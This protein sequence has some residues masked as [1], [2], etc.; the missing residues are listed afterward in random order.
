MVTAVALALAGVVGLE[1]NQEAAQA[2][3]GSKFDPGLIISDSVYY[4]FGAMTV[5]QVQS[6]LNSK[7]PKC[8]I[9]AT[10]PFTCL[11]DFHMDTPAKEAV[12]GRCNAIDAAMNQ[13]AAE[14]I[15]TVGRACSINPRVLLVTLQKSKGSS[16][17]PALVNPST[18]RP[19]ATAAQTLRCAALSIMGSSTR[20]TAQPASS[21]GMAT[22][23]VLS[24]SSRLAAT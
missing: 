15:V 7:V 8:K 23:L 20:F 5:S 2:L 6:F 10:D 13:S 24:H 12:E 21:T 4:D 14:I 3:D 1:V 22:Q 11:R 9:A 18:A 16:L 17:T 19:W